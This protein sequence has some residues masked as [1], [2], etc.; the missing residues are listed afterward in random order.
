MY[1]FIGL[2]GLEVGASEPEVVVLMLGV[3]DG[4]IDEEA[5]A[6]RLRKHTIAR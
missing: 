4:S 2:N 6:L 3:A 1:V 5:V